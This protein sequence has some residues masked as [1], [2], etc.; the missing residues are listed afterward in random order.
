MERAERSGIHYAGHVDMAA[1][2]A[3]LDVFVL[4]SRRDP[5]PLT[6]LE[7]MAAGVPVVGTRVDGI[8]EQLAG[9]AG[10]LV[11]SE[12]AARSLLASS[13]SSET[14]IFA[15]SSAKRDA[16]AWSRTSRFRI[17]PRA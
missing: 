17:R 6:V 16:G 14:P 8:A 10:I 13:G 9:G 2:L 7:A 12:D 11:D 4:P 1:E 15:P 3:K 5:F